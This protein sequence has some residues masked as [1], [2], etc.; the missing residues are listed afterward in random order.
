MWDTRVDASIF[1]LKNPKALQKVK[2][3]VQS[4]LVD[5]DIL[6]EI[7]T[8]SANILTIESARYSRKDNRIIDSVAWVPGFSK[9]L[10]IDG[11]TVFV[12]IRKVLKPEPKALNEAKG[13]ITADYQNALEKD[14]IKAL[15][16]KY[17]VVVN[18]DVLA[19]IK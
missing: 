14:W 15:R 18:K 19:K 7:N 11:S 8:D 4:G 5:K 12:Y 10:T 1:T 3:F 16:A 2:N 17:P 13:L 9:D 6:K